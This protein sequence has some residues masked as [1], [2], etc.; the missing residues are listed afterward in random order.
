MAALGLL[1]IVLIAYRSVTTWSRAGLVALGVPLFLVFMDKA[2]QSMSAVAMLDVYAAS[3]DVLA[4]AL[5]VF[6]RGLAAS[7]VLGLAA[8]A[9]YT[10]IFPLPGLLL[11]ERL[12]GSSTRKILAELITPVIVVAL[13]WAPFAIRYSPG[14]VINEIIGALKWHTTSRPAGGPPSTNPLGLL[15]G[16]DVFV[17][18]YVGGKPYL[19]AAAHPAVTLPALC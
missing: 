3:L 6:D 15:L 4:A 9:K 18:Y 11:Y 1:S 14:W 12:R 10:G 19:E 8:S 13:L 17:L 16:R 5:M 7:F 2:V